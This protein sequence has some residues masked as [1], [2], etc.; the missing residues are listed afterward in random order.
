MDV[1]LSANGV[2]TTL[3]EKGIPE[4]FCKVFEGTTLCVY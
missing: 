2:S 1:K 4:E 3:M